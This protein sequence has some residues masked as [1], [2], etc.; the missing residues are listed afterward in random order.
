MIV[1]ILQCFVI[2]LEKDQHLFSLKNTPEKN[3]EI[4]PVQWQQ[5]TL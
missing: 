3:R 2:L 4:R 1:Y 5:I